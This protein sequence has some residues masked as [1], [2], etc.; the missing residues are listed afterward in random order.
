MDFLKLEIDSLKRV[1][2]F[3]FFSS[4]F[5]STA[6]LSSTCVLLTSGKLLIKYDL[7]TQVNMV[8][9]GSSNIIGKGEI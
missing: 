3:F 6:F 9:F 4:D 7:F 2:T 5:M 8:A 1:L